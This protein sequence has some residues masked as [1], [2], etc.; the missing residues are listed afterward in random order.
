M[1][2]H[3]NVK[4]CYSAMEI[5]KINPKTK[6]Q[7]TI[8]VLFANYLMCTS[9]LNF[10]YIVRLVRHDCFV[11]KKKKQNKTYNQPHTRQRKQE[12]TQANLLQSGAT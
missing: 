12:V 9:P 5:Y 10:L 11:K 2:G 8:N 7:H 4:F 3:L 1:H 6:T